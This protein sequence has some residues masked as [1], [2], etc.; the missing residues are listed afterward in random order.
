M[1][2][3]WVAEH[4]WISRSQY[5]RCVDDGN[6]ELAEQ[7]FQ[8][9][10]SLLEDT[11][12]AEL[13]PALRFTRR[14]G[15]DCLKVQNWVGLIRTV[16]GTHIEVLPKLAREDGP[17][18]CRQLLI[19]MLV[20]LED[21]PFREAPLASLEAHEMPL[22]ELLFRYYLEQVTHIVRRGIA[23]TYVERQG[24][25]VFLRGK[26]LLN[27]HLRQNVANAARVYCRYDEYEMDRPVNRLI[28]S[29]L[30]ATLTQTSEPENKRLCQ[31]LLFWFDQVPPS[32]DYRMDFRRIQRDRVVQHYEKALAPCR[33]IL[34]QLN[35]LTLQGDR[36]ALSMLFPMERVFEHYVA[37]ILKSQLTGWRVSTQ[38][39][40]KHLVEEHDGG[41][42]FGLR[43]DLR[44]QR[45]DRLIIA[46]TK[47]KL[48]DYSKRSANYGISQSDIYQMFAYSKRWLQR[49]PEPRE[50]MLIYPASGRFSQRLEPFWYRSGGEILTVH[51][52]DLERDELLG[53]EQ[54][55]QSQELHA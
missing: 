23:R 17:D 41:P 26:L 32:R 16:H 25:L 45:G 11:D 42:I 48:L 38:V 54:P 20:H 43:P 1:T 40:G 22:L 14:G 49:Q 18:A 46:D 47:W 9:L 24:N 29:A 36:E 21:S 6:L 10:L 7:D 55:N 27:E 5:S 39:R 37:A 44:L 4:G 30:A 28:R 50:V 8:A 33:M 34:E 51:P 3:L 52:F 15:R 35:P 2:M 13:E 19:K 53:F 12:N 31:E